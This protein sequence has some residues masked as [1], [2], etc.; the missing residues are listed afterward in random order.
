MGAWTNNNQYHFHEEKYVFVAKVK[1]WERT[2]HHS[3]DFLF[4]Q[5]KLKLNK[6]FDFLIATVT[7][8]K[9]RN[10]NTICYP[11]VQ[12]IASSTINDRRRYYFINNVK[13]GITFFQNNAILNKL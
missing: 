11:N 7:K 1:K 9:H 13:V 12:E 6:R 5:K 3:L 10:T 4:P 8:P 2:E